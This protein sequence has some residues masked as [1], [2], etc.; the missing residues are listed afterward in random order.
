MLSRYQ[1]SD[2]LNE[3]SASFASNTVFEAATPLVDTNG[4]AD[5]FVMYEVAAVAASSP[6]ADEVDAVTASGCSD[7]INTSASVQRSEPPL[8]EPAD[9]AR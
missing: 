9:G 3:S 5:G 7:E 1:H 6:P 4:R 2:A 8:D